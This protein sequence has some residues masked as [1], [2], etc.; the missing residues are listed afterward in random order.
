MNFRPILLFAISMIIADVVAIRVCVS[1]IS[2]LVVLISLAIFVFASIILTVIFKRK[3]LYTIISILIAM[4]IPFVSVYIKANK[5]N[6]NLDLNVEKC[7]IYGKIYKV[8]E[9]LDLNRVD[10]YLSDVKLL[11]ED[12]SLNFYGNYL[13]RV[14][15]NNLELSRLETGRYVKAFTTPNF[16]SLNTRDRWEINYISRDIMASSYIFS[17]NLSI[18]DE[19]NPS[20]RD[21]VRDNVYSYFS[22]TNT[23]FTDV[24]YAMLFGDTSVMEDSVYEVFKSSGTVHLLAVSGFH[25]SVIVAFL[26]FVLEKLRANNYLSFGIIATILVFYAYLCDFSVSV[27]RASIMALITM[28]AS[29]RNKDSD[30]LSSMSIAVIFIILLNPIDVFNISFVLSFVSVLSIILLMPVLERFFS[31]FLSDKLASGISLSLALS[32]GVTIFQLYY[33]GTSPVLSFIS[34]IITVPLVS[35]L[36]IFLIISVI[37]GP[38]IGL[39]VPLIEIFG[40][41]I[42]YILQFNN[43]IGEMG[44]LLVNNHVSEIT[45][46]LSVLLM[47]S[48][49]DYLF[50]RRKNKAVIAS[51]FAGILLALLIFW[52]KMD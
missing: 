15:S 28:F 18:L 43:W 44:L 20:L 47:Y 12:D 2:R 32:F 21:S 27:I 7:E 40:Y 13:L 30:R 37:I 46:V 50:V 24:G 16:Y 52:Y 17:Y 3:F 42:K 10:V 6:K 4:L 29:I 11:S 35:I 38:M 26:L 23:F 49:S 33:F 51:L 1:Q 39:V 19:F 45:L 25:I 9:N 8:N 34:N 41:G 48:L 22:K 36:F 5:I 14:N 31:K